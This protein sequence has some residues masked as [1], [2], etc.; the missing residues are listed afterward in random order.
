MTRSPADRP[1]VTSSVRNENRAKP[2]PAV[3]GVA[4][5]KR[6]TAL[7]GSAPQLLYGFEPPDAVL[8]VVLPNATLRPDTRSASTPRPSAKLNGPAGVLRVCVWLCRI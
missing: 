4:C 1:P 8:T 3:A 5:Q 2:E 7:G 6:R